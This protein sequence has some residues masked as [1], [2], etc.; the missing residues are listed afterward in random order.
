MK[1][2]TTKEQTDPFNKEAAVHLIAIQRY[3]NK[4]KS[5]LFP[6]FLSLS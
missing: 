6:T 1:M 2:D 5:F 3:E 4:L